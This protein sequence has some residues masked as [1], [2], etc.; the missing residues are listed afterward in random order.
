MLME[1]WCFYYDYLVFGDIVLVFVYII[2][3]YEFYDLLN[4]LDVYGNFFFVKFS[5]LLVNFLVG[6]EFKVSLIFV[7]Y[8][9]NICIFFYKLI[10]FLYFN[11]I[12]V[13]DSLFFNV[14]NILRYM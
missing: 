6:F 8:L 2:D 14:V 12:G 1:Y 5:K 9:Y 13:F 10:K 11:I 7:L 3:F 4:Y